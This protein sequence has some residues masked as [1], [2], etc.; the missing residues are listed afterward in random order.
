MSDLKQESSA[1]P[2]VG[3]LVFKHEFKEIWV[4]GHVFTLLI[5]FTVLMS[6]TAFLLATNNEVRLMSLGQTMLVAMLA[7][8]TF[9]LFI[10]LIIAAESISGERER[11]TLEVLL[12]TPAS[13]QQIVFG[14]FM[15]AL[16]P[17]PV[18]LLLSVP[19]IA[20]LAKG[21][22]VFGQTLLWGT[23]L[24]SLLAIAFI[25]LGTILSIWSNSS[26][27]SLG[28]S[29]LVYVLALIPAQLPAEF[30]KTDAGILVAL[31]NPLEASRQFLSKTLIDGQSLSE[32]WIYL[33]A[34]VF[35]ISLLVGSLFLFF[36][37]RL[38]L[39]GGNES[40]RWRIWKPAKTTNKEAI[41]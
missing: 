4:G 25:S 27:I 26:R 38:G 13:R 28:L 40:I 18:T 29:L 12:L 11:A 8:I 41:E 23:V 35:F 37:P 2:P 31:I 32:L 34:P 7:A 14:K 9:G 10:G 36:A 5:V 17:W 33:A 15:A 30:Q 1:A 19:Y 6:V 3:W 22:P 21:D 16:T 39:E 24:G 20:V